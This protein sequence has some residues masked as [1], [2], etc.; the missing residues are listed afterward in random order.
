METE[1]G[2]SKHP[3]SVLVGVYDGV[4]SGPTLRHVWC[5]CVSV[6]VCVLRPVEVAN[7]TMF[8]V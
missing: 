4:F 7:I 5:V 2:I 6:S 1:P 3:V 8:G